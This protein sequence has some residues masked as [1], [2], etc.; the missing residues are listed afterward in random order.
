MVK[1]R[2]LEQKNWVETRKISIESC[3][4][5]A[6]PTLLKSSETGLISKYYDDLLVGHF[7]IEKTRNLVAKKYY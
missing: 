2:K 6:Y 5:K 1:R 7:G 4:I 3:I